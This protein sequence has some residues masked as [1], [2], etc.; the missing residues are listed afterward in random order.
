MKYSLEDEGTG[1]SDLIKGDV[2][3]S[4]EALTETSEDFINHLGMPD[5]PRGTQNTVPVPSAMPHL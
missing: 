3:F 2:L 4:G 1:M 5:Q